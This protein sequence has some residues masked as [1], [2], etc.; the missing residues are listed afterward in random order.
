MLASFRSRPFWTKPAICQSLQSCGQAQNSIVE[1]PLEAFV[2]LRFAGRWF[3]RYFLASPSDWQIILKILALFLLHFH[4]ASMSKTFWFLMMDCHLSWQTNVQQ[5]LCLLCTLCKLCDASV[6]ESSSQLFLFLPFLSFESDLASLSDQSLLSLGS[7]A[8]LL[9][10]SFA[11]QVYLFLSLLQTA[12]H[13]RFLF[14][15]LLLFVSSWQWSTI[16]NQREAPSFDLLWSSNFQGRR[17]RETGLLVFHI[18]GVG[19]SCCC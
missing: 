14:I 17:L 11:T 12:F 15:F 19:I 4:F 2:A 3:M 13:L 10:P 18:L 16:P 1:W 9:L 5:C 6:F 7:S 8:S